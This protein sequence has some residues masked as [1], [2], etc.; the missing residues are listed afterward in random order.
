ML[1]YVAIDFETANS[2]RG[3]PCAVGLVRVRDGRPVAEHSWLIRPPEEVDYFDGYNTWIHGI[4]ADMVADKPRWKEV[5]PHLMDFVGDDIVI[6]H[7]AGFDIGVI[8]YACAVDNIEWPEMRFLCTMV[9]A[10]RALRLP[11]Y[12]LPFVLDALGGSIDDHHDPLADARAVVDVVRGLSTMRGVD[13][14]DQ[15]AKSVGACI[16]HMSAGIYKGSVSAGGGGWRPVRCELNPDADPDGYLFGRVVVFTGT[17]MSMTRQLA[18]NECSAIGAIAE[19]DTT[20]RTNVLV[21]GDINPA[22]LRPGATLTKKAEMAFERQSKGQQIEVMTEDDFLRC[23]EGKPLDGG[24]NL[25]ASGEPSE[26]PAA[27]PSHLRKVP[28]AE[29]PKP[30]PPKP[31]RPLRRERRSLTDQTCSAEGCTSTAAF[32][33]RS[34]PTWCD[35][36]IVALQRRGGIRPLETFTHPDDWQLTECLTCTVAAHY[37]FNYTLEKNDIGEVTCRACYWR[38]WAAHA[39]TLQGAWAHLE[40]VPYEKARSCAEENGYDYF[41]PLTAPSL[42]DD[43]HHVRCRRCGK[44]SAE[45]LGDIAFGCTCA[46][47][48]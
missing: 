5:L 32:L 16:G 45:R 36:H 26:K 25:L 9:L 18:W 6:A 24:E 46:P 12:R 42:P 39:R 30:K 4:T 11:S 33:T 27:V 10:R 21:I 38:S 20:K 48:T 35:E 7:N 13:D 15:L 37:R 47:R 3:S 8:R 19:Q 14:L 34:K 1:N 29:R 28:L 22:V 40:P 2:Y 44:I 31:P 17:L 41:G 23:L 43:P